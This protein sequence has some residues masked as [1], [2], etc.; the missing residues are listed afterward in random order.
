MFTHLGINTVELRSGDVLHNEVL[1]M[2]NDFLYPSN[3]KRYEKEPCYNETLFQQTNFAS[4]LAP[5]YI[6]VP[7]Y[8]SR[9]KEGG[10]TGKRKVLGWVREEPEDW[11]M[12]KP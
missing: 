12:I 7:L 6:K 2:T 9:T 11:C 4:P 8:P 5:H 10:C 3:S 1:R